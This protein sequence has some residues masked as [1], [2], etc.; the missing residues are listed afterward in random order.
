MATNWTLFAAIGCI[1]QFDGL[2]HDEQRELDAWQFL[3]DEGHAWRLQGSYG[4][5]ASDLIERGLL[6]LPQIET[7]ALA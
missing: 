6:V 3:V 1:E 5:K 4:R 2:P 7:R